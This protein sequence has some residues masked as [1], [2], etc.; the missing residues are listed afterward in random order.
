M[1]IDVVFGRLYLLDWELGLGIARAILGGG[2]GLLFSGWWKLTVGLCDAN[3]YD[4][5]DEVCLVIYS[6]CR[7]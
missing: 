2:K 6:F 4:L 7:T 5:F 3:F 1:Y